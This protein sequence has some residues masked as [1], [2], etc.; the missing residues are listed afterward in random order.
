MALGCWGC[1]A[2]PL[3]AAGHNTGAAFIPENRADEF[4]EAVKS[5]RYTCY[6]LFIAFIHLMNEISPLI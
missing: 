6:L 5:I 3:T 2:I 1:K 4:Q